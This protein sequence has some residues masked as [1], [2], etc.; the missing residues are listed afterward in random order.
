MDSQSSTHSDRSDPPDSADG[1]MDDDVDAAPDR[2]SKTARK[3]EMHALQRL[4]VELAGLPAEQLRRLDLPEPLLDALL[5]AQKITSHE[6]RRR[7]LQYVGKLM[8]RVDPEPL[9]RV[10]EDGRGESRAAVALMHQAER[11]RDRLLEDDAVLT[12]FLALHP[13][14]DVQA[15][16]AQIRS[17]RRERVDNRPPRHARELYRVLHALLQAD[18]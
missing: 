1:G 12:E 7:H 2:P 16:R 11:W 9:R 8:R 17:A 3:Q 4:G 14:V 10:L 18:R 15:L 6:G 5:A 13:A